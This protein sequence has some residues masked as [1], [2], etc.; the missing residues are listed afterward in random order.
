ME[1]RFGNATGTEALL[2]E[3]GRGDG[4]GDHGGRRR[5]GG[6]ESHDVVK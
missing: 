3:G 2:G 6:G 1:M 5:S 4:E